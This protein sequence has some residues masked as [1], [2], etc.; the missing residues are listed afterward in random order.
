MCGHTAAQVTHPVA[1]MNFVGQFRAEHAKYDFSKNPILCLYNN[2]SYLNDAEM[3]P[4]ARSQIN[5]MIAGDTRIREV[6]FETR[7]DSVTSAKLRQLRAELPETRIV[8]A[9]GLESANDLVR[10][11]CICKGL[12]L[13]AFKR[14][15]ALVLEEGLDLR[16]Y[17]LLKPP[18]LTEK[19]AI[20]DAV[21]SVRFA[22]SLG[23]AVHIECCTVQ[24]YTLVNYLEDQGTY[25]PPWLWS[26]VEV[27]R[28]TDPIPVYVTPFK[29]IPLPTDVPHNCKKCNAKMS[30]AILVE[31]NRSF[32]RSVLSDLRC[33][34][35][36][37]WTHELSQPP[38]EKHLPTRIVS[39][40][41][42]LPSPAVASEKS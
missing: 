39:L 42:G 35:R 14:A 30:K 22:A 6:V 23:G 28:R 38:V 5:R 37:T 31:Y 26:I 1:P 41:K 8:I 3:P 13:E 12:S 11:L 21:G 36:T 10:D 18:F 20:D 24:G 32:D 16:T 9:M 17:V 19:E 29:Y 2:G 33:Q 25:R 27:L 34:C 7:A 15:A 4:T 40:L